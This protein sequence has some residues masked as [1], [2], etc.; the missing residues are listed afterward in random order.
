MVACSVSPVM[1]RLSC[2]GAPC[3]ST[4]TEPCSALNACPSPPRMQGNTTCTRFSSLQY[5]EPRA[6]QRKRRCI[7]YARPIIAPFVGTVIGL[8][9]L[10]AT[11]HA[12]AQLGIPPYSRAPPSVLNG[13][14]YHPEFCDI[15]HVGPCFPDYLPPVGQDLRLTIISTD[16]DEPTDLS[17]GDTK[18]RG[19]NGDEGPGEKPLDSIGE[20]YAALR[21]C[22][23]PPLKDVARHDME[24][25]VRFAFKRNGEIIAPP[26]VTYTTRGAPSNVRDIY[27][28]AVDAAL[29]RCTPLHLSE[30][31]G[32]AVAGRPI[33]IRFV[34]KR[35]IDNSKSLQ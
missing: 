19:G 24:Y 35:T 14:P 17:G 18:R 8:A 4:G 15:F 11:H 12:E 6:L 1:I 25:T 32:G 7:R 13:Q 22:W 29:K 23:V 31:M 16:T 28:R 30:G 34:D 20:M 5:L 10:N 3:A 2:E 26:R 21:G 33:A 9:G 27:G